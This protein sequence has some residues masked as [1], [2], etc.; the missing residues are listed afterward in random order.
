[1]RRKFIVFEEIFLAKMR[2]FQSKMRRFLK[3]L[4]TI[5]TG[6]EIVRYERNKHNL[7]FIKC[8]EPEQQSIT[9]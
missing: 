4:I 8:F 5:V 7:S 6:V 9:V 2:R 3:T 1:M